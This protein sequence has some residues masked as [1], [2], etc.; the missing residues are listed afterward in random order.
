DGATDVLDRRCLI[1]RSCP[2]AGSRRVQPSTIVSPGRY[3]LAQTLAEPPDHGL[4]RLDSGLG[5]DD[6]ANAVNPAPPDAVDFHWL[7]EQML[8]M[9]EFVPPIHEITEVLERRRLPVEAVRLPEQ[10][11]DVQPLP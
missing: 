7:H 9:H 2:H 4:N 5:V 10:F 8:V 1:S 6:V 11:W 3:R